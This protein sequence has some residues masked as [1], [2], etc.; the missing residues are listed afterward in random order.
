MCAWCCLASAWGRNA[1]R[2]SPCFCC[3]VFVWILLV[4]VQI[5]FS[6][7]RNFRFRYIW[8]NVEAISRYQYDALE[9]FFEVW[10]LRICNW[11]VQAWWTSA[12]RRLLLSCFWYLEDGAAFIRRFT[13]HDWLTRHFFFFSLD[14]L[15]SQQHTHS[16]AVNAKLFFFSRTFAFSRVIAVSFRGTSSP[17]PHGHWP[18]C[19]RGSEWAGTALLLQRHQR[20]EETLA[21]SCLDQRPRLWLKRQRRP[22]LAECCWTKVTS[23]GILWWCQL[24]SSGAV[25][26]PKELRTRWVLPCC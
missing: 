1:L 26:P 19:A 24:L 16:L 17:T 12:L 11:R 4:A 2:C 3:G 7:D 20:G 8:E 23:D 10:W 14:R 25:Q 6:W 9:F 5:K 13:V 18:S 15:K 22:R 21:V